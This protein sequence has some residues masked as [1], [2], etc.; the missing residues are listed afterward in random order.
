MQVNVDQG[1]LVSIL[2]GICAVLGLRR[3][4]AKEMVILAGVV[5]ASLFAPTGSPYMTIVL[6]AGQKV[7]TGLVKRGGG[8]SATVTAFQQG[9]TTDMI[10]FVIILLIALVLSRMMKKPAKGFASRFVGTL[11]GGVNGYM[12]GRFIFPRVFQSP[13]TTLVVASG[14][15]ATSSFSTA[16]TATA[17]VVFIIVLI[18]LGIRQAA[19][20][21]KKQS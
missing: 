8:A 19:P 10:L 11:I 15:H 9:P 3:G 20:P 2:V 12:L 6:N 21:K 1:L 13:E 4:V 5:I 7:V 18:G 16:N 14:V 17:V